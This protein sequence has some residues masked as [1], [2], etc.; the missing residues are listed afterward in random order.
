LACLAFLEPEGSKMP[1]YIEQGAAPNWWLS[2]AIWVAP[3]AG[4][5]AAPG[6]TPIAGDV[7]DVFV[8]VQNPYDGPVD[9][10]NLLVCW[11]IPTAGPIPLP[12]TS[13]FLNGLP[14]GSPLGSF[15]ANSTRTVQTTTT[16]TPAFLNG[17]HEC[18][19]AVAYD[20]SIGGPGAS[21]NGDEVP[22]EA[23]SIAQHNLGVLAVGTHPIHRFEYGFQVCNGAGEA[24]RFVVAA[25]QAPLA[26]IAAFLPSVPGGRQVLD[27]PGKVERLGVVACHRPD[28][29]ALE[30]ST[31]IMPYID[32]GPRSCH[33]FTLGGTLQRGNALIHVTQSLDGRVVGG[34]S[35]LVMAQEK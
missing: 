14:E 28:P 34:L 18:L 17:G 7:Y 25:R 31:A 16:W 23:L 33:P 15:R 26:E 27:H 5:H 30:G 10:W 32:I 12:P 22:N 8:Q 24:R 21:L 2:P 9:D 1:L 13:Q 4:S 6:V 20:Q 19:I 29:T 35:V 11:V 3:V